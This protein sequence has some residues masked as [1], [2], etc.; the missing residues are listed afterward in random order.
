[1]PRRNE[2]LEAAI[3][4]LEGQYRYRTELTRDRHIKLMI[5][6]AKKVVYISGAAKGREVRWIANVKQ[7]VRHA[8]RTITS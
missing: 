6:G 8:I 7:D 4:M 3:E 1:M 2:A 5:D